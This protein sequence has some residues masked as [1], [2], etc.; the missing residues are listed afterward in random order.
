[1]K[2]GDRVFI[3]GTTSPGFSGAGAE[4][5]LSREAQVQPLPAALSFS[6]GAAL[7]VPYG[8]AWRSLFHRARGQAGETLLVH[9]ASGGVGIASVQIARAA[10]FTVIGTAGTE[11]GLHLVRDQGAHHA[12]DHKAPDYLERL[13]AITGGR[14]VD[15]ILE[16]ASHLNLA[17][18]LTV[19]AK[20][21]RIVVIGCRGPIEINPREAMGRDA[22]ILG[23]HLANASESEAASI[24]AGVQAGLSNGTLRP[25]IGREFPLAE[26]T[27]AHEA[28]LA[29]GS[30][31][32][33]V[34]TL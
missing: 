6:Q 31:G 33:I 29:P 32:K 5:A 30:H 11:K 18:D 26:A 7:Y 9:G 8:T 14:G 28:V 16:M 25:V 20:Y 21:G 24:W 4:L 13:M 2:A 15:V 23:M 22:A 12:L 3:T 10:G 34:L 17:K 19:L 1:V 27:K